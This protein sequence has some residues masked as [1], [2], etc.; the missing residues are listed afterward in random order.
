[1]TTE[2]ES[3][4]DSLAVGDA[5]HARVRDV[6][7]SVA[8][9]GS[10]SPDAFDDLARAIATHQYAHFLGYRRLCA[11]RRVEPKRSPIASLPAVPTDAFRSLR[12]ATFPPSEQRHVFRTSGTTV[13]TRGEHGMRA[14]VTYREASL[15]WARLTLFSPYEAPPLVLALAPSIDASPDSSLSRMLAWFVDELGAE[16]SRFLPVDD[17]P[18]SIAALTEAARGDRPVVVAA[19]AFAF[20][21]LLDA[22]DGRVLALPK[23]SRAMQTGGFKGRSREVTAD[24]LRAGIS[25]AFAIDARDVI[26]EY[27]MTELTSQLYATPRQASDEWI[28]RAPP[29][30]RVR[31]CDPT[32]LAPLSVGEIGIAR[33]E[34]LANVESA[35]AIQ[36]ADRVQVL[37]DGGVRL[38]GR[39]PGATPRGCS[40][41]IEEMIDDRA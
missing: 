41:A 36:T 4:R 14:L 34:D 21:H 25:G 12:V 1:M 15:A 10:F 18:T 32:T 39:L 17:L 24:A 26:G 2:D 13:G 31:A 6:I 37:D 38:L 28:Y 35:W 40:L 11:I 9:G 5:L 27:G 8:R 20:V 30:V 29:W 23:G 22:L 3:L 16:R 33:I 7:A 19:T